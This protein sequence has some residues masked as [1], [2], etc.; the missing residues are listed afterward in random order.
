MGLCVGSGPSAEELNP[1]D[2]DSKSPNTPS[3][4]P[5]SK[6]A[7]L[8]TKPFMSFGFCLMA[9]VLPCHGP[10][11]HKIGMLIQ[12]GTMVYKSAKYLH[13]VFQVVKEL[14]KIPS[15]LKEAFAYLPV[16]CKRNSQSAHAIRSISKYPIRLQ[17]I[18]HQQYEAVATGQSTY[19]IKE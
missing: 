19:L 17:R 3:W 18:R 15:L 10:R 16:L 5:E 6:L 1:Q 9:H 8:S 4:Q 11:F 13:V 7:I 14:H 2:V 12:H